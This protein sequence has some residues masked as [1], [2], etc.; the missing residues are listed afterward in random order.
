MELEHKFDFEISEVQFKRILVAIDEDDSGSSLDAFKYAVVRAKELN[1]ALG[2]A[3]VME[4]NELNIFESMSKE[5]IEH[6][7]KKLTGILNSYVQKANH[8]G[9]TDVKAFSGQGKP[10]EIIINTI[11]P[12]FN[13]D[14]LIC[15]SK[16]RH[17]AGHKN[18]FMGSQADYM[19]K[20]APCSIM[21]MRNSCDHD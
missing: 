10:G 17:H 21:V 9:L 7:R 15:G 8:Y 2:I 3:S 5:I 19:A 14:L 6:R 4:I 20:N 13:P 1:A 12:E 18:F 11:L 16:C